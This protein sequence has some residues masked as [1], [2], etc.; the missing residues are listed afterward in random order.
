MTIAEAES[1]SQVSLEAAVDE[2]CLNVEPLPDALQQ[3]VRRQGIG[4]A[5]VGGWSECDS[6]PR[7]VKNFVKVELPKGGFELSRIARFLP[8]LE[9]GP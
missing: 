6:E 3:E 4:T 7:P 1:G 5:Q 9:L 2:H 8:L